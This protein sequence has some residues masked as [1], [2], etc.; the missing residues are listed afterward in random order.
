MCQE[1][2][3]AQ[4]SKYEASITLLSSALIFSA[5][6][7]ALHCR[8]SDKSS[9]EPLELS[10]VTCLSSCGDTVAACDCN[11]YVFLLDGSTGTVAA[12]VDVGN[13]VSSPFLKIHT[14]YSGAVISA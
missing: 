3:A 5:Q 11:G 6:N 12:Q 10:D 4:S 1:I 7:G 14:Y 8:R 13:K 2:S 9:P